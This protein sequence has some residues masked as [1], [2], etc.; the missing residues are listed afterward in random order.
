MVDIRHSTV[1]PNRFA[2][3]I[4]AMCV[5]A[6]L[7]L[8]SGPS[9]AEPENFVIDTE[10]FSVGFLVDHIGYSQQLGQF[11]EAS[12]SFVYDPKTNELIEGE[13]VIEADSV[14][15]NHRRRDGHVKGR[16]FLDARRHGEIRFV[17]D[18]WDASAQTLT[19]SLSML[20][21]THP[22]T[23]DATVNKL[24]DYPFGHGKPTLGV[25]IRGAIN[26]SQWGMN[27]GI[28]QGMVGDEVTVLI[29]L[30]AIQQ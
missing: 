25:S 24:A 29:E 19:G 20:G 15:T 9:K 11:L 1:Q 10:H 17:A 27:Y 21:Q 28:D 18:A 3:G 4:G 7:I 26:R 8:C 6:V 12:G 22:V 2:H 30:E 14:F 5:F 16:D 23:L 13:V